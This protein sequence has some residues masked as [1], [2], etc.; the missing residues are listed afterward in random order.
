[1]PETEEVLEALDGAGDDAALVTIVGVRGS[2]YRREGAKLVVPAEGE[3]V[4]NIS[5]GCLEAEVIEAARDVVESGTPTTVTYDLTADDEVVWGWGLGCNGVVEVLI[6]P[7]GVASRFAEAMRKARTEERP[8]ALVTL[9]EGDGAGHRLS[10]TPDGE[11]EGSLGD[12]ALDATAVR[13]ARERLASGTS[14]QVT[15]PAGRAFVEAIQPPPRLV[16]CGAGHD[17]IPVVEFAA[18]LGWRV[19]VVD[20]REAFLTEDRFPGARRLVRCEPAE[21][22]SEAAV[23]ERTAVVV[24]SHNFLR[25]KDY[26]RAFLPAPIPYLAMLGPRKRL[27]QLL[28]ALEGE[29]V[30][31]EPGQ[32][33]KVHGPAGLDIGA[34]GPEEI[35][36]AIISEIIAVR[37]GKPAGH[38]RDH[39][40]P[41]HEREKT[42]EPV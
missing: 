32:L 22:A 1:M 6:E 9:L 34:E 11:T 26:L 12:D 25:D 24:M 13:E 28:E 37:R 19:D 41:I 8:I 4:G 16:V 21:A 2:T 42:Q 18:R 31:P 29:G 30:T 27:E 23:D 3:P 7:A 17:A 5:G 14:E 20:D 36:W 39:R 15:L 38:L 33:E 40:G 10:V 35:A